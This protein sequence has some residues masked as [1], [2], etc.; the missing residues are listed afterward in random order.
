MIRELSNH[1]CISMSVELDCH[2]TTPFPAMN[3]RLPSNVLSS[4]SHKQSSKIGIN[5][6]SVNTELSSDNVGVQQT[7]KCCHG[8]AGSISSGFNLIAAQLLDTLQNAV[9]KR[10]TLIQDAYKLCGMYCQSEQKEHKL[11]HSMAY[12]EATA[13]SNARI[14]ILFSGGVDSM[15][16]AALVDRQVLFNCLFQVR[17]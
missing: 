10:V 12:N 3:K 9:M 2:L 15:V 17:T 4:S 8:D 1:T 11:G 13:L 7:D 6:N 14:A 16:L 5:K